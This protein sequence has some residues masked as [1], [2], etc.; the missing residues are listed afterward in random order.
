MN[1]EIKNKDIALY[2]HPV[3]SLEEEPILS[4]LV[5]DSMQLEIMHQLFEDICDNATKNLLEV[6]KQRRKYD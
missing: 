1:D 4:F 5:Q 6:L 2:N 3:F